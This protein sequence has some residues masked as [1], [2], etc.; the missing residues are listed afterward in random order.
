MGEKLDKVVRVGTAVGTAVNL[1]ERVAGWWRARAA[2][3]AEA[4]ALAKAQRE[5]AAARRAD[6]DFQ[7]ISDQTE[8]DRGTPQCPIAG[9]HRPLRHEGD[10]G[11]TPKVQ[12]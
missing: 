6:L 4:K 2:A 10:H 12:P 1:L 9:C 3:K 11:E 5:I 8:R 7:R